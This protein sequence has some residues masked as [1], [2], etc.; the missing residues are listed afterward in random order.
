MRRATY[1]RMADFVTLFRF[2]STLSM[3]RATTSL[4]SIFDTIR[5]FQS[6]LSMRRATCHAVRASGEASISIHALHE[7]S[8][9]L[10]GLVVVLFGISIHAL[11]EESDLPSTAPKPSPSRFQST[12]S[13]R[14]AT[15]EVSAGDD[16]VQFQSTLS[17]RRATYSTGRLPKQITISIHA[18]HEESDSA[19]PVCGHAR[20]ISIHALHEESDRRGKNERR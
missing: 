13:M 3:R 8:D 14:R 16:I 18:L 7:E 4:S 12:L 6:T 15:W 20:D 11:H 2:Q 19:T 17:M 9:R 10:H 5:T 1:H